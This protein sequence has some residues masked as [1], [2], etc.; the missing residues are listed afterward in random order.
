MAEA[1]PEKRIAII[2]TAP[3][4]KDC[5][6]DDPTLEL[7]LLNDMHVLNPPRA[8]RWFDLHPFDKMYFRDPAKKIFAHDVPVG[9]FVRPVGHVEFLRRQTIPVYVQHAADLG[10]PS[11]RTFPKDEIEKAFGPNFASSPAWMVG[12]ALLEG[13]TELH[14]YGIHLATEWEYVKQKPNMLLLIGMAIG[15]GVKVVL[16]K[17]SPLLRESHQYGYQPDPDLA[18]VKLQRKLEHVQQQMQ[19]V[20][21]QIAAERWWQ[22]KDPN[23]QSRRA[24]LKA[25]MLDIQNALQTVI[26]NRSPVGA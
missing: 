18:K 19:I 4:W 2:G 20:D 26:A 8:D 14:I 25:Q 12:L 16:P 15:M 17:G 5:P 7:W 13:V 1:R 3:T 21:K 23:L 11:A 6:W 9:H 10:S 22:V 24:W